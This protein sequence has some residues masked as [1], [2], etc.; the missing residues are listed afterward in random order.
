MFLYSLIWCYRPGLSSNDL[1]E[2]HNN[3]EEDKN[4]NYKDQSESENSSNGGYDI[5]NQNRTDY[6]KY[7]G[8][9]SQHKNT[10]QYDIG[11]LNN[12]QFWDLS[13]PITA[14]HTYETKSYASKDSIDN[15]LT[16]LKSSIKQEEEKYQYGI[17]KNDYLTFHNTFNQ[18]NQHINI[19]DHENFNQNELES[20]NNKLMNTDSDL[21]QKKGS[22]LNNTL[23]FM[24]SAAVQ[25]LANK[26]EKNTN[27]V[28]NPTSDTEFESSTN[29]LINT[30]RNNIKNSDAVLHKTSENNVNLNFNYT[31][32]YQPQPIPEPIHYIGDTYT[33]IQPHQQPIASST[34]KLES[35]PYTSAIPS[36]NYISQET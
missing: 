1:Y 27:V 15:Q 8:V 25:M 34:E 35:N 12:N 29:N 5:Y 2:S 28:Q 10:E 4:Y 3:F 17:L 13:N 24:K 18:Q 9:L 26:Y 21:L 6:S 32:G 36:S 30:A 33:N 19:E 23:G 7:Q 20:R 11:G 16:Q 31:N 22:E 14:N